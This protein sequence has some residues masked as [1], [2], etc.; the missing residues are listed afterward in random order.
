M[1]SQSEILLKQYELVKSSREVVIKFCGK[2][3]TEDYTKEVEGFGR[4]SIRTTQAHIGRTYIFWLADFGMK[5]TVTYP[6]YESYN[7]FNDVR[8]LF[9]NVDSIVSEFLNT[10]GNKPDEKISGR[11][12]QINKDLT[13]TA[14]QLFTHTLTHEFHHKGQIMSM[15]RILGY[16]PPD[17]DVIRFG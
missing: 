8:K 9:E 4:G 13:V 15:A 5:K 16:T 1:N 7:N 11:V 2:F 14:L 17:A 12:T 10:F 6:P 3:S